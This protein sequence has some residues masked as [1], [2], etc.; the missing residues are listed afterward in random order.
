MF[1]VGF[2]FLT[3]MVYYGTGWATSPRRDLSP[4]YMMAIMEDLKIGH[5]WINI[6]IK[7]RWLEQPPLAE[8]RKELVKGLE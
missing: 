6:M 5:D 7:K 2:L 8:D 4:K 1:Q 3:A